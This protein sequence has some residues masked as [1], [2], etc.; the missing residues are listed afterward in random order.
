MWHYE[1]L[2]SSVSPRTALMMS[3]IIMARLM[4]TDM[5]SLVCVHT[6]RVLEQLSLIIKDTGYSIMNN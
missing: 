2:C 6:V 3:G 4:D 5:R 1:T